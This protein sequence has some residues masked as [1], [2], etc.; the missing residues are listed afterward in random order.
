MRPRDL[1]T[2]L[3]KR[4]AADSSLPEKITGLVGFAPRWSAMS[5]LQ[6]AQV[7]IAWASLRSEYASTKEFMRAVMHD[8]TSI[9]NTTTV[10]QTWKP[11]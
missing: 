7:A 10:E 4:M 9:V 5:T 1:R 11:G 8:V 2:W 6:Y 3:T